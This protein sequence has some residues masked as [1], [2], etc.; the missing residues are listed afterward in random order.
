MNLKYANC[1]KQKKFTDTIAELDNAGYSLSDGVI[2][3]IRNEYAIACS[4]LLDE[5]FKCHPEI[6]EELKNEE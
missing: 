4:D 1:L 5:I 3:N 2:E 6:I